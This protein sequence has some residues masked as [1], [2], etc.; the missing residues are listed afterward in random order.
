MCICVAPGSFNSTKVYAGEA[1]LNGK[2][3]HVLA[4]QNNAEGQ[5]KQEPNAMILP[6]PTNVVM[7]RANVINTKSFSNFLQNIADASKIQSK[8]RGLKM[9]NLIVAGAA[10]FDVFENGSYTVILADNIKVVPKAMT[11]VVEEKRISFSYRFL[12]NFDKLYA[13]Q[14]VAVCLWK[15]D[16]KA[17]PL[18][19]WYEPKDKGTLFVPT[20]DSHD[21]NGPNLEDEV[22]VDHIISVGS[23]LLDE[24]RF[25]NR[26]HYQDFLTDTAKQLLPTY[27]HGTKISHFMKNGDMFVKV[28][29]LS[30]KDIPN[31]KRGMS[32]DAA[33]DSLPLEGWAA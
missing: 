7:D 2:Y 13:D 22:E 12:L 6:F 5:N 31:M 23:N 3:V 10:S 20:M 9:D 19:W 25:Y 26:V 27:V 18:L 15:G 21:G 11:H 16:V 28:A 29:D 4:Y 30:R 14:P 8:S 17:E 24:R 32:Y 33:H 1:T